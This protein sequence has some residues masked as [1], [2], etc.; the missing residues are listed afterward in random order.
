MK[1]NYT[2][3][4]LSESKFKNNNTNNSTLTRPS[5]ANQTQQSNISRPNTSINYYTRTS[6]S[7]VN[8]KH[9]RPNTGKNISN[10]DK[11]INVS[12]S[13]SNDYN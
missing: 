7:T 9:T 6:L 13:E 1:I 4:T 12:N 8:P 10:H 11:P 2:T 5:T 3:D